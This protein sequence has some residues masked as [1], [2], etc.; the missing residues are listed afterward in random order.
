MRYNINMNTLQLNSKGQLVILLQQFLNTRGLFIPID[1]SFGPKTQ[2]ALRDYQRSMGVAQ[3]GIAHQD[4]ISLISAPNKIDIWCHAI[5]SREGY[6]APCAQYPTGTPAWR[7]NNPGNI[8]WYG[9]KNAT[10]N[11]RFA[12]YNTYQDGYNALR[13][14]LIE[15]CSGQSKIY[16]AEGTLL[17]FYSGIFPYLRYP[18]YAPASDGNDP[19][20]YAGEVSKKLGVDSSIIIKTILTL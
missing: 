7:N 11:G 8:E 19:V 17:Q 13:T 1:G 15:A 5:Q 12:H 4:L 2:A 18:G 16:N 3:D 14:L 9:Q 20:S 10:K 6:V